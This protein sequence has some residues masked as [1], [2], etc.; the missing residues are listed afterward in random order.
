MLLVILSVD[1]SVAILAG[2]QK[3]TDFLLSY[4]L[5]LSYRWIK[6]TNPL[7]IIKQQKYKQFLTKIHKVGLI[8]SAIL[9]STDK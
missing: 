4:G 6:E 3:I 2:L 9:V 7:F 8:W 1:T 5:Y